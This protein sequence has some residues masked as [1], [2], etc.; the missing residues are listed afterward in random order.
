MRSGADWLA[1][2]TSE[3]QEEFLNSLSDGALSAL[4]YLFEFWALPHQLPPEGNWR[5]WVIMGGRGAGK[6]RAGSEWVRAEVEGAGPLDPG[7]SARVA[8]VGETFDQVR[9]VM[10]FGDSGILAC[11]PPDRR[12]VWEAG[13]KRLLWP[14]GA[15]AQVFSAHEPEALRG[16]QFDAA[17]VD[18]LGCGAVDKG[19][20]Q[21]NKFLDPKS[22]ESSLPNYSNGRRDDLIQ[23]QYLRAMYQYWGNPAHNVTDSETGVQM[24]DMARAHVWA[25]DARPFPYFPGNTAL[26]SDGENYAHGH[27]LNGRTSARSLA[28]VVSEICDR[29][30]VTAYDVSELHGLVRGYSV[31]QVS[32]G[33]AALQP[34]MLAYGF[35]AAER[36]GTLVFTSRNGRTDRVLDPA[37]L[38]ITEEQDGTLSL[39][40]APSAE[41]AGRIRL[42]FVEAEGDY[43]VRSSEAVFPDEVSRAVSQ[44]EMP[45]VLL[46]SEGRAIVERWLAE[47]RVA[48][49]QARFSLPPSAIANMAGDVVEIETDAGTELYRLD[50]VEQAGVS[51]IQAVRIEPGLYTPSDAVE[52]TVRPKPFTPAVPVL[53]LFMDLPLLKGDEVE[54]APH[55]AVTAT[56]WPGSVAAW[57]APQDSAYVLNRLLPAAS[58]IGMTENTLFRAEPGLIDRGPALRVRVASG[59]LT[60]VSADEVLNGA[61]VAVIGDGSTANWEV[62]QFT[63]ATLVEEGVYDLTTR[64]RGQQGSDAIM[65]DQWPPGSYVVLLNGTPEQIALTASER[66]LLRHYRVGPASRTY[67]DPVYAHQVH[68]FDG[69]G[70]RPYAPVHLQAELDGAGDLAVGWIRRTR[71]D[72]DSWAGVEVPLGEAA[73]TYVVRVLDGE[74]LLRE[75]TVSAPAWTYS[76]TAQG[77]DGAV[78]PFNIDVAQVSDQFGAGPFRRLSVGA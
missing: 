67:N 37:R 74:V 40:R 15:I 68:A 35:E 28:S 10:V 3:V 32:S 8:L 48:R 46:Q 47:S 60:S 45:L 24:I 21:P 39:S 1:C 36:E 50:H 57:S 17:W 23:M 54:H 69:I 70:L 13:R 71:T 2:A 44:S 11:S 6:T 51:M 14:N 31:G 27:W 29:S 34:L 78:A 42:N 20:N 49:D 7:R 76:A 41:I 4:P 63:N 18:E 9:E 65:P 64:L 38:A 53:P 30:G 5:T 43:E 16:P 25:W 61:N 72:G 19:T 26:W 12:P 58:V 66:G 55:L 59:E 56:P 22:S 52:V 33:R 77:N 75:E 73:E 62:F